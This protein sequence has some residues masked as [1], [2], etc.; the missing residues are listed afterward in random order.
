[1][2]PSMLETLARNYNNRNAK[3]YLYELGKEYIWKGTE[4]LPAEPQMLCMGMYGADCNFFTIKGVVEELLYKLGVEDY[5]VEAVTDNPSYHPGRTAEITVDGKHLALLGEI[6]P[7]V[8]ENYS[9]D[10]KVYVAEI[11]FD[12]LFSIK[13]TQKLY[14]HLPKYPALTRDLAFVCDRDKPVLTLEKLMKKAAG[15]NLEH[16]ELF[17]VY[18]GGN[19]AP[20]KKS[21]AF[22]LRLRAADRTLTDEE[23]DAAVKKIIK[24]L[25]EE[26]AVL[27]S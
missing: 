4:E 24:A 22:S 11:N 26:G 1:M 17:D 18:Q 10:T 3:A 6:H 21:V 2:L 25:A 27:R 15:K 20:D 12:F 8:L 23:A 16:I 7:D 13:N 5:D 14:K 9:V 19:I